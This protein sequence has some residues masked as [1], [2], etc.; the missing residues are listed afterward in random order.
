[1][2]DLGFPIRG[3]T[4]LLGG[5]NLRCVHFLAKTYVKMKEMDPVGGCAPAVPPPGSTNDKYRG[6]RLRV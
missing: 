5:T 3:G 2:V 6:G 4:N 1:M